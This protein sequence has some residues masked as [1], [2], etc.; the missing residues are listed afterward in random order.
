YYSVPYDL[1]GQILDVRFTRTTVEIF[2]EGVR[3]ASH[4][5]C[6][7]KG[8]HQTVFEHMPSSHQAQ[9]SWTPTRILAWAQTIGPS[10]QVVCETIMA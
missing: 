7:R 9:A 4:R 3:I 5:R 10:T 2:S 1:V 8:Q 6:E